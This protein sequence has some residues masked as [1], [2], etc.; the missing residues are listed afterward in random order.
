IGRLTVNAL[1]AYENVVDNHLIPALGHLQLQKLQV[2]D[3]EAYYKKC[4]DAGK[5]SETTLALHHVTLNAALKAAVRGTYVR[6]NP[7]IAVERDLK[8][9]RLRKKGTPWTAWE[10]K[11]FC[12]YVERSCTTQEAALFALALDSGA[13]KQE[14]LGLQ[15]KD[16]DGTMLTIERQLLWTEEHGTKPIYGLPKRNSG[17][18][19]HISAHTLSLLQKHKR[20]QSELKMKNRT[21]YQDHDLVFA[22]GW[23]YASLRL[24]TPLNSCWPNIRLKRYATAAKVKQIKFHDLRHTC[25]T[26][27][28]ES[29]ENPKIVQER[30]G[31]KNVQLTLDVYTH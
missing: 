27:L 16:L 7:A 2:R 1:T 22:Y 10:A 28:F 25:A 19:I 26:L 31:H 23:E 15:W 4:R 13:R 8:P 29:G 12:A 30:I 9:R 20:E 3:I 14:L 6:S 21:T 5:L 17:R 24:V 18:V 11:A